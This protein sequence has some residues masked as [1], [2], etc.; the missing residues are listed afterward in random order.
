MSFIFST[1]KRILFGV[2]ALSKLV[3]LYNFTKKNVLLVTGNN[4]NRSVFITKTLQEQCCNLAI[5]QITREPRI[6]DITSILKKF[7]GKKFD[8]V[9]GYGG[10]SVIDVAK[11]ISVMLKNDGN[12][13]DYLEIIG[14]GKILVNPGIPC[15]AI[16]TTSGTGSES[17]KNAVLKSASH[18]I[19]VSLR[20]EFLLPDCAIVDP[21]TTISCPPKTTAYSGLDALTQL[22][23]SYVSL[24]ATPITDILCLSG[25]EL[26]AKSLKTCYLDGQN[27]QARSDMALASLYGGVALANSRL[28][29]VHGI[30][31]PL[32]GM[33]EAP[34]GLLCAI[35]LPSIFKAN[36]TSLIQKKKHSSIQKF[37]R[38]AAILT[39]NP[40]ASIQDGV[41]WLEKLIQDLHIPPLKE[42]GFTK[43]DLTTL[44][45]KSKRSSSMKGNPVKLT[46]IELQTAILSVL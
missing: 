7:N 19:K 21:K 37:S 36:I 12:I 38:I 20:H 42:L 27:L 15:I 3:D 32:G 43:K 18:A 16:P 26:A 5:Q 39:K 40:K 4:I 30:A 1:S 46:D 13:I 41:T 11:V 9:L 14:R 44:I 35:F 17:T 23:E 28:G 31:G 8:Y 45:E 24:N 22:I 34:H 33:V 2:D 6:E 10:G 29:A 25:I